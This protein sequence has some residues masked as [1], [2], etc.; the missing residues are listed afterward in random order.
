[1][2]KKTAKF[3][4]AVDYDDEKTDPESLASAL[5]TLM[6]TA[7]STPGIFEDYGNPK[8]GEFYPVDGK[9]YIT[10]GEYSEGDKANEAEAD[11]R[12]LRLVTRGSEFNHE[13]I[14]CNKHEQPWIHVYVDFW[15]DRLKVMVNDV[16]RPGGDDQPIVDH[17]V[18]KFVSIE[19]AE[20]ILNDEHEPMPKVDELL[21]Q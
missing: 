11:E 6:E 21:K 17:D 7:L 3:E 10:D 19:A 9:L 2:A 13:L 1:M 20:L 18:T 5:D 12:R 15:G 14:V 16:S 4:I 8:V